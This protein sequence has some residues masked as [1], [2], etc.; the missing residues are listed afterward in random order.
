M[1]VRREAKASRD[2]SAS[3][4][5]R[6]HSIRAAQNVPVLPARVVTIES[7]G[8]AWCAYACILHVNIH[9]PH[10]RLCCT[11]KTCC[12]IQYDINRPNVPAHHVQETRFTQGTRSSMP[13]SL[14]FAALT[15]HSHDIVHVEMQPR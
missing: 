6:V 14:T 1:S 3:F 4:L 5:K 8:N 11:L 10:T 2:S 12:A 9:T 7:Y 15:V 13:Q